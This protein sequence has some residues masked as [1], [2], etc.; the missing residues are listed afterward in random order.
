[1]WT[2]GEIEAPAPIKFTDE[3]IQVTLSDLQ[4]L[5]DTRQPVVSP[6]T[7]DYT[8]ELMSVV[9]AGYYLMTGKSAQ[10]ERVSIFLLTRD[11]YVA[12]IDDSF[13]ELF[14]VSE[15]SE[16]AAL[17]VR[18][19]R[20]KKEALG[21]KTRRFGT[22]AV[23]VDAQRNIADVIN[24]LAHELGHM[25]QD[26][27][28]PDQ[29]EAESFHSLDAL[30]EAQAQQFERAFWLA[31]EDFTGLELFAYPE[32]ED[33]HGLID[34]R[35]DAWLGEVN[36]DEHS[37]GYLLQWLAVLD[38]PALTDLKGEL[39]SAAGL[40]VGSS[41]ALYDYLVALAPD[42]VD[43]YVAARLGTIDTHLETVRALSRSRLILG[44]HPDGEGSPDLR[45]AALLIP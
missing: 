23:V 22:V 18:R 20:I 9:D 29:T 6:E 4:M 26:F 32:Y 34:N 15:E 43:A 21:F 37:L 35:L 12:W 19:E 30:Q 16:Y 11:E 40:G 8:Q 10:D 33:F 44:L 27:L 13:A 25:R 41:L 42:S 3:E 28:N 17:L 39:A 14:A 36:Q 7:T 1:M 31:L 2:V 45:I 5:L 38:D 24:T